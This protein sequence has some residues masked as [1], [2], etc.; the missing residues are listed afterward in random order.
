H[1]IVRL[2]LAQMQAL[3]L[4]EGGVVQVDGKRMTAAVAITGYPE[5]DGID[6]VRMDGLVRANAKV[7]I[8]DFVKVT[9]AEWKEAKSVIV[10]PA[11]EGFEISGSGEALRS[12]LLHRPLVQGDIVSTSVFKRPPDIPPSE[13]MGDEFLRGL[14]MSR[15]FGLMEIRL[16]VSDTV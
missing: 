16:L 3:G 8:G 10:A 11:R 2:G 1:G 13:L 5:D 7:G 12:T 6:I 9:A 4:E 14:F 15:A